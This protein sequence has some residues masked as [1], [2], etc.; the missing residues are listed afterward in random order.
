MCVASVVCPCEERGVRELSV[1]CLSVCWCRCRVVCRVVRVPWCRVVLSAV[2][3]GHGGILNIHTETLSRQRLCF[4]HVQ[5]PHTHT[6]LD[7]TTPQYHTH[8]TRHRNTHVSKHTFG[9]TQT[10]HYTPHQNTGKPHTHSWVDWISFF[11]FLF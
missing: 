3:V 9:H 4:Y 1:V 2:S 6:H 11:R 10:H 7:S 8:N 5:T